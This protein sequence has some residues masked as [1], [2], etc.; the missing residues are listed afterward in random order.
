MYVRMPV[1]VH[2]CIRVGMHGQ[3]SVN[4]NMNMNMCVY[5]YTHVLYIHT[6]TELVYSCLR[7]QVYTNP[8]LTQDINKPFSAVGSL[9]VPL[10][11]PIL[12]SCRVLSTYI[13]ETYP[14]HNCN[15]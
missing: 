13:G 9:I 5:I 10:C 2:E 11:L 8:V 12:Q 4:M 14:N 3:T 6:H 15:S 7:T 1:R